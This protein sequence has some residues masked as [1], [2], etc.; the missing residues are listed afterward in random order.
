M[1][2][3]VKNKPTSERPKNMSESKPSETQGVSHVAH[4]RLVRVLSWI[5]ILGIFIELKVNE[6]PYMSDPNH[7]IRY[8][9]SLI[10]HWGLV[11]PAIVWVIAKAL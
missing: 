1:Q 4:R 6:E 11:P 8:W 3:G 2:R 7:P 5:P 10:Y 9:A